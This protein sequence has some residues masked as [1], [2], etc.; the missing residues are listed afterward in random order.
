M[1][2]NYANSIKLQ[3]AALGIASGAVV[4]AFEI[5]TGT[6]GVVSVI[7][8]AITLGYGVYK[9]YKD[10][11]VFE[12]KRNFGDTIADVIDLGFDT[13]KGASWGVSHWYLVVSVAGSALAIYL[14]SGLIKVEPA[15]ISSSSMPA[16]I[17]GA[18]GIGGGTLLYMD[19]DRVETGVK[20]DAAH[21]IAHGVIDVIDKTI[22][23]LIP[24]SN[25]GR[26]D[27][28]LTASIAEQIATLRKN[29][30]NDPRIQQLLAR[31]AQLNQYAKDNPG[32]TD[33]HYEDYWEYN[34]Q[35]VPFH[36]NSG[37]DDWMKH[38]PN[39]DESQISAAQAY[40]SQ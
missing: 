38:H 5:F 29:N 9:Y 31:V 20:P 37:Y 30:P 35:S 11:Q 24:S 8:G 16:I 25:P 22:S 36:Y 1:D 14:L 6:S 4:P 23:G 10:S 12:N 33:A 28:S 40:Y 13:A 15:T 39:A 27:M 2:D 17:G 18:M 32:L 7:G 26:I 3:G 19:G 21:S 34:T